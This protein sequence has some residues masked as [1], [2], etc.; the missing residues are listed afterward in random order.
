MSSQTDLRSLPDGLPR[1][2]DDGAAAHLTG[3]AIPGIRLRATSGELV[4][5]SALPGRTVLYAYPMTGVPG[6]A[7]PRGWDD[8]PG[9]RGCTPQALSFHDAKATIASL[10]AEVFGLSTQTHD[11]QRELVD[12]LGLTFPILSDCDHRLTDALRLP[13]M[14]VD[15]GRLLRRLTLVIDAGVVTHTFYPVFPPDRAA[16]DVVEWLRD[17]PVPRVSGSGVVIYTTSWCPYCKAAK[18]LLSAKGVAFTEIDVERVPGAAETM[19]ARSGRRTVPQ[20][21]VGQD[22]VGGSDDL[23]AWDRSG[24][25]DALL[26]EHRIEFHPS[27]SLATAP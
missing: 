24:T 10:G 13:T 18:A 23:R 2:E 4:D 27:A 8:V 25:L 22:H 1:P 21:F 15:G 11:Y 17:H 26:S 3:M 12:R 19:A 16:A 20:I 5:L 9:A 6:V 7:L 14:T